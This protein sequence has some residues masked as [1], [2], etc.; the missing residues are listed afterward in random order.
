MSYVGG[1]NHVLRFFVAF[2]VVV[3]YLLV[4]SWYPA[5]LVLWS[6]WFEDKQLIC[7]RC[8]NSSGSSDDNEFGGNSSSGN[9]GGGF[10][11][12][13]LSRV[14]IKSMAAEEAPKSAAERRRGKGK[15][16]KEIDVS[17]Y[18]SLEQFFYNYYAPFMED[19]K[20]KVR[21]VFAC[22]KFFS[23]IDQTG[24]LLVIDCG[25][26]FAGVCDLRDVC[27]AVGARQRTG[28]I[29]ARRQSAAASD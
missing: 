8:L 1:K 15:G 16:R 3:N 21:V 12:A 6:K 4:I 25:G 5:V 29:S 20:G 24:G 19:H 28:S 10:V 22:F 11:A 2:K 23:S 27:G 13:T 18:R 9:G 26:L 7:R 17:N 14:G